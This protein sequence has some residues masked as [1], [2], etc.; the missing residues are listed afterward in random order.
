[1]LKQL[2]SNKIEQSL[3]SHIEFGNEQVPNPVPV[4][5]AR[6]PRAKRI[7][8]RYDASRH[9][10]RLTLPNRAAIHLGVK[11]LHEKQGWLA[12]Q[13]AKHTITFSKL[14]DNSSFLLFGKEYKIRHVA[15][16]R[17]RVEL[18]GQEINIHSLPEH[19]EKRLELW[20]KQYL[21][22]EIL[23]EV[24]AKAAALGVKFGQVSVRH[25]RSRWGSCSHEGNLS[26]CWRVIFAPRPILSYLIAHEVAHLREMNHS[27][28]FWAHVESLYPDYKRARAWL[29]EHGAKLH[30]P[31]G[32][33][34]TA[35]TPVLSV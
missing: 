14:T 18:K 10:I 27:V 11:F 13:I 23:P 26:F 25:T 5:V 30:L 28:A 16:A 8:L 9:A 4:L 24:E 19:I 1:M 32:D 17:G 7:S 21:R 6:H 35:L 31:L 3:P 12:T 22:A 2:F 15:K 34:S 33:V 20:L 29:S